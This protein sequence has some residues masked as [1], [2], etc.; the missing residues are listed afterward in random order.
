MYLDGLLYGSGATFV[1][2]LSLLD[3]NAGSPASSSGV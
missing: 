3:S 1:L 2:V